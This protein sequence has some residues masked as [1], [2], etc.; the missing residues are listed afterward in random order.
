MEFNGTFLVTIISFL[1]F[2]FI[3]NKIL[4]SPLEKIVNERKKFIDGNYE[5]AEANKLKAEELNSQREN[6]LAEAKNEARSSYL[7]SV[8]EYKTKASEII[9]D[10]Q[11]KSS[12]ELDRAYQNLNNISNDTKNGL[13]SKLNELASDIAEKILGYK[14]DIQG[15]DDEEINK[16]L[17]H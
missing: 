13:K 5:A 7:G 14:T 12:D 9:K 17:Y 11:N 10:A 8:N 16:I 6:K 15:F 2:V 3:M 4:Y 1:V